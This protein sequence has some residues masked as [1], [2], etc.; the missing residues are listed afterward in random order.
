MLCVCVTSAVEFP[1]HYQEFSIPQGFVW[2]ILY[3]GV[4]CT[5]FAQF[6][7]MIA[8]KYTPATSVAILFSFE[9]VFGVIFEL[10]FGEAHLT[11][12]L[13]IGFV[14]IFVAEIISEIGIK[15]LF[16]GLKKNKAR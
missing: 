5:L 2:K 13:V 16:S 4:V 1:L 11:T 7:Q 6:G 14:L 3:L 10:I 9:A 12:Y 8:Q 15:K